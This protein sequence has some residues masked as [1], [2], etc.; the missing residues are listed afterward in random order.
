[1]ARREREVFGIPIRRIE[2]AGLN[3]MQT[4]RQLFYD[5]WLLRVS[6]GRAKRGRSI[7]AFFGSTLPLVVKIEH[8]RRTYDR[9]GLPLL[10]RITPFDCPP[11]L[12]TVL[13]VQGMAS[14]ETTLVQVLEL[15]QPPDVP[16]VAPEVS[17]TTPDI[18]GFVDAV[19]DLRGS[20]EAHRAA[21][22]ER[23]QSVALPRRHVVI[24]DGERVACTATVVLDGP[25]AGIFDVL[26][27]DDRRRRG[28]ATLA[29][30]TLLNWAWGRGAQAAYLQVGA[31][32]M[33]AIGV[34]RRLGFSTAYTYHYRG[35]P[36]DGK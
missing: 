15:G 8:C 10:F 34:Y 12:D 14:F 24:R 29:C 22:R 1:M 21:H 4:Q 3:A 20:S 2:E 7:N 6:P 32:N 27:A 25:L 28:L 16:G 31:A 18:D 9:L 19:G 13:A 35:T 33:A 5:G 26:T 17:L 23:L 30:T 36:E 11:D